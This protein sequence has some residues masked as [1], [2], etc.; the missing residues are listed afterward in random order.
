MRA[1]RLPLALLVML[2]FTGCGRNTSGHLLVPTGIRPAPAVP[3]GA[4]TGVVVFDSLAYPGL[5]TPPFPPARVQVTRNGAVVAETITTASS[6][7]FTVPRLVP[8]DYGVVVRSHAFSPRAFGPFRVVD[9]T[10]DAGD[11]PLSANTADSLATN[12]FVIGTLPGYSTDELATFTT[13]CVGTSAGR[14]EL[15]DTLNIY[16][17]PL[18]IVPAGTY[19]LKFVTDASS[20]PGHLIGWGGDPNRTL[21]APFVNAPA[22]FGTSDSSDLVV[23]FPT[24]GRYHFI[25]DERR[26]TLSIRPYIAT[27]PRALARGTTPGAP[28]SSRRH[29]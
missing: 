21:D 8:G 24:T 14:W 2:A 12:V 10:R 26:L 25:F 17:A 19:R 7:T 13:L 6:N 18:P 27:S 29:P 11:L 22:R 5:G 3:T 4:L 23:R 20:T 9:R 1:L 15:N 16:A 28:P